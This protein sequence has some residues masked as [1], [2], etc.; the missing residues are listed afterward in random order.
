MATHTLVRRERRS[1]GAR[2]GTF[3][4]ID[5]IAYL[6]EQSARMQ[7]FS[8]NARISGFAPTLVAGTEGW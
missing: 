8:E 6:T 4:L 3:D 1:W 7:I 5:A 2:L